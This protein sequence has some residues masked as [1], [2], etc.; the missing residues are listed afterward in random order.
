MYTRLCSAPDVPF[1]RR[2]AQIHFLL[3]FSRQGKV[4]LS[5]YYSTFNQKERNKA[6]GARASARSNAPL[7]P[8]S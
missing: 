8:S 7:C 5:K 2:A 4:R 6:R 1:V 3:L